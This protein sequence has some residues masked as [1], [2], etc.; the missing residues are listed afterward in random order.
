MRFPP[1]PAAWI[2]RFAQDDRPMDDMISDLSCAPRPSHRT[3]KIWSIRTG[4][5]PN[6][7]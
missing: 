3:G 4:R 5:S 7:M 6:S 2:L 1:Q